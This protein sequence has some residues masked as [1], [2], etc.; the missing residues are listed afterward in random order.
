VESE[1][2]I[3]PLKRPNRD[4]GFEPI[5]PCGLRDYWVNQKAGNGLNI[6]WGGRYVGQVASRAEGLSVERPAARNVTS[7]T[8]ISQP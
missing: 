3:R 1:S 5:A 7:L 6:I 4:L 2:P 8:S